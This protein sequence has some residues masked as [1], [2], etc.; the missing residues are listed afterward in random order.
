MWQN[1]LVLIFSQISEIPETGTLVHLY[2]TYWPQ[3]TLDYEQLPILFKFY[4][5]W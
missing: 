1:T 3:V 4:L 5:L 2:P